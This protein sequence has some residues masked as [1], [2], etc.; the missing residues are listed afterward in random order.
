MVAPKPSP[1]RL[2][3]KVYEH[4]MENHLCFRCGDKYLQGHRCKMKKLHCTAGIQGEPPLGAAESYKK[5]QTT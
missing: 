2:S 3:P 4:M 5:E 1:V